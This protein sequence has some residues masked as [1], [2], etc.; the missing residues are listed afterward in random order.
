[1]VFVFYDMPALVGGELV[2]LRFAKLR[3]PSRLILRSML[4]GVLLTSFR[5]R[6]WIFSSEL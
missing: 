1:M 5:N 6:L 2:S 3:I 4:F